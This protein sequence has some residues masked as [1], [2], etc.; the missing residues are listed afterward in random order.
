MN[1][2]KWIIG[3]F[4]LGLSILIYPHVAQ[5]VNGKLHQLEVEQFKKERLALPS[6]II[7]D[8]LET[9]KQCN[10]S[11]FENEGNFQDPFTEEYEQIYYESCKEVVN[12]SNQF[13]TIEIPKLQLE[14]PIYLGATENELSRG[15]GQVDGS[16]LPIGGKN[17]HTVLAGHRGMGTKAMFRNLDRVSVNDSFY[18]YTLEERLEYRVYDVEVILPHETNRLR[19]QE[20]KDLAS[21]ITCHPYPYNSHRLVVYGER[22]EKSE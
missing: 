20:G 6:K 17:T 12:E 9:A 21:L 5:Y 14:I 11:I 22:V 19:I 4:L 15:I 13:A 8:R 10:Q 3:L 16:S 18:I 2:N 7:E 1:K